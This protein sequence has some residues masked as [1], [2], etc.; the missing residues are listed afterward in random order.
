[1]ILVSNAFI[2]VK[3]RLDPFFLLAGFTKGIPKSTTIRVD[4]V[5]ISTHDPPISLVPL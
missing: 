5:Q 1:M 4:S 3:R 2:K